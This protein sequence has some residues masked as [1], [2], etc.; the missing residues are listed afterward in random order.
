M[1]SKVVRST[2]ILPVNVRR[3]VEKAYSVGA[4]RIM[5]DLEDSVPNAE[6]EM[7]R[8]LVKEAIP[9]AARGGAYVI[10]RVN[11]D[12][13]LLASD[14]EASIYPGLDGI[15]L[16]KT[17]S[18]AEV[19]HLEAMVRKLEV[20]RGIPPGRVNFN[21][22][23]ETPK[24]LLDAREI[25]GASA[26][27][28]SMNIGVED[29]SLALGIDPSPDGMELLF[30]VSYLVAVCKSFKVRPMGL[31]GSVAGFKD[32]EGYERAAVRARQLGC[33]GAPCIHPAQ[34]EV[35][36]RVFSPSAEK[37]EYAKKVV[38]AFE[39]GIKK[40]TASVSLDGKMV[41][42]PVYNRAKL[43][44]E[45]AKAIEVLEQRKADALSQMR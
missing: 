43:I 44:F 4:D 15:T 16:P 40:G 27:I 32:L 31:L 7:A 35:L 36:N 23:V 19:H 39:E 3:F 6:K 11:N 8:K 9:L 33:E 34:V 45:R 5:L 26:R 17:E 38:E 22:A 41:D 21:L 2:L 42:V 25:A 20:E 1:H 13:S 18:A 28:E 10:V 37:I 29:Y 14:L 12:P 24:G 30:A